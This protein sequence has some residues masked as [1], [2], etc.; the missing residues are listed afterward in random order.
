[1]HLSRKDS[2]SSSNSRSKSQR[3][4]HHGYPFSYLALSRPPLS[5]LLACAFFFPSSGDR[6]TTDIIDKRTR[7][8]WFSAPARIIQSESSPRTSHSFTFILFYS[9]TPLVFFLV[10]RRQA[11]LP[12][13]LTPSSI[14][15]PGDYEPEFQRSRPS[16]LFNRPTTRHPQQHPSSHRSRDW[17]TTSRPTRRTATQQTTRLRDLG[18]RGT[19]DGPWAYDIGTTVVCSI[20]DETAST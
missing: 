4:V 12:T 13:Q 9:F 14:W 17:P 19:I 10:V 18:N 1:L 11:T 6:T 8:R 2:Y 3:A 20:H 7:S 15:K 5:R 16:R